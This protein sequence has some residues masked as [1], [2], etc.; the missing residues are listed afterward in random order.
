MERLLLYCTSA[1]AR[2]TQQKIYYA[3]CV[4]CNAPGHLYKPAS[5]TLGRQLQPTTSPTRIPSFAAHRNRLIWR[6]VSPDASDANRVFLHL[7]LARTSCS[8]SACKLKQNG[9]SLR[10]PTS[11]ITAMDR[12]SIYTASVFREEEE[13]GGD[14]T[15]RKVQQQLVDFILEFHVENSFKY[16]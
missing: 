13:S 15:R 14:A 10:F 12:Q 8:F 9:P 11:C 3:R 16:R 4:P 1:W 5:I 2:Q 7:H 6:A